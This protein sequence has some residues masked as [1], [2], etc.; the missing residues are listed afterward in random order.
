MRFKIEPFEVEARYSHCAVELRLR[1]Q[2][3][4]AIVLMLGSSQQVRASSSEFLQRLFYRAA[5]ELLPWLSP[6][7]S[8]SA[9]RAAKG[10]RQP[11][12]ESRVKTE[13]NEQ[14]FS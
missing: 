5:A 10:S 11:V 8:H 4:D 3:P 2:A 9:C 13:R 1:E 14:H 12:T 6:G 7:H